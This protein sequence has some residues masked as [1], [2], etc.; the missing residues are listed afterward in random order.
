MRYSYLTIA[1]ALLLSA[2]AV[3][4]DKTPNL[5]GTWRMNAQKS[6]PSGELPEDQH[7]KI[8]QNG[9][10][11]SMIWVSRHKGVDDLMTAQYRIG[12]DDNRN[13]LHGGAMKSSARWQGSGLKIDSV[14]MY[15]ADPLRLNNLWTLST[16]GQT[17]TFRERHQFKNEPEEEDV[18]VF[19]KQPDGSWEPP[20]GDKPA[21]EVYKNIQVLKGVPA[22]R[23]PA[24]MMFFS[25]SLGVDCTHCHVRNEFEKE[26][27][28]PKETARRMLRMVHKIN[29]DNFPGRGLISCWTCHRGG[30]KPE[31][32]PK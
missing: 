14:V 18:Y 30:V 20:Q 22:S 8:V 32:F 3:S 15:G 21:E 9:A 12:S 25:K 24:V 27:K 7:L 19:D 10:D 28:P 11:L 16:D 6:H 23:V 29:D 17:L 1:V 13:E 4:Q 2:R 5:S 31:S 26:D